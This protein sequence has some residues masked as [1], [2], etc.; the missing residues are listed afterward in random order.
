M[1]SLLF[2]LGLAHV[3]CASLAGGCGR[4]ASRA[5]SKSQQVAALSASRSPLLL[6]AHLRVYGTSPEIVQRMKTDRCRSEKP[7]RAILC[8]GGG[9][10][11]SLPP[12]KLHRCPR[13]PR[14]LLR[15]RHGNVPA[16]AWEGKTQGEEHEWDA[17][18]NRYQLCFQITAPASAAVPSPATLSR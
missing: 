8:G 14:H 16:S 11:G 9:V 17:G 15:R 18:A 1:I 12:A 7:A 2:L 10:A 6:G 5:L 4:A 13:G 3:W